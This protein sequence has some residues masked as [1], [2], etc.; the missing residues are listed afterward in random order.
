MGGD[1]D[2]GPIFLCRKDVDRMRI[3][4]ISIENSNYPEQLR[5]IYNPPLRLY[6]LGNKEIL[7]EPGVAI[8]GSRKASEYGKKVSFQTSKI[9][10]INKNAPKP[11]TMK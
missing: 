5:K 11:N 1:R 3:E 7:N 2:I 8:V 6:V 9:I 10:C 4:E